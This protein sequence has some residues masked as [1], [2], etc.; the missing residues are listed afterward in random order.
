MNTCDLSS[1]PLKKWDVTIIIR[2]VMVWDDYVHTDPRWH[3]A[4]ERSNTP[5]LPK[6]IHLTGSHFDLTLTPIEESP[7]EHST[8]VDVTSE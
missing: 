5:P 3:W 1:L 7:E 8:L 2:K 4:T 6:E